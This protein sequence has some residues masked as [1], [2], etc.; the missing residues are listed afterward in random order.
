MSIPFHCKN[1]LSSSLIHVL[2]TCVNSAE[3][4]LAKRVSNNVHLK[5][6]PCLAFAFGANII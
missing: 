2:L 1:S 3:L 4:F 5:K 6:L